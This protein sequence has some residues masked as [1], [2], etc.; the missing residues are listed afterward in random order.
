M[1]LS[2]WPAPEDSG[3]VGP[4]G[5]TGPKG[6]TG[7]TGA[8]GATGSTGPKGDTGPVGAT[9]ATGPAG[10]QGPKG[11][12]GTVENAVP[13]KGTVTGANIYLKG[14]G[15]SAPL[16]VYGNNVDDKRIAVLKSGSIYSNADANTLYSVGVG[17]T[18]TD[19]AGGSYV[20]AM[21][22]A[23]T[24][25][26][27][28][29]S[30]GV[31]A[32]SQGGVFKIKQAD[33]STVVPADAL[34]KDGGT[35]TGPVDLRPTSG[36]GFT[37]YGSTA[38]STYFRVTA[39]GHPYS[40]SERAT[41]YNIGV[42]DTST[43]FGGGVRVLGMQNASTVPTTNPPNGVVAYAQGGVMKVRQSDG[44]VITVGS[45]PDPPS[46]WEPE[47][48]GLK[49]WAGD[50]A[51]C[52]S[53]FRDGTTGKGR[54]SAIVVHQ[55]TTV[56]KIVWHFLGYAG[57]MKTGSWAGIYNTSGTLVRGTG[58]LGTS[59]YEP[60]EQHGVGG[61][62]S[63]SNLTSSVTLAP[64]VYYVAW[65]FNYTASPANGPLLMA[66]ESTDVSAT[67]YGLNA[68]RRFGAFST[69][70]GSAPSSVSG[71]ETDPI[72]FWVALA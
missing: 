32:Y 13:I 47:D 21:K 63:T 41:F 2:V 66:F 50:P 37:A 68:V 61:G 18:G 69:S 67:L 29:P 35:V 36:N 6:D 20:L 9:G 71:W 49:A 17:D 52:R 42:G 25:P 38:P 10:P 3:V 5:A 62:C 65:R 58:D 39:D 28:S 72:R 64:G 55:T 57:G 59:A 14:D 40:N 45:Q 53:G 33:G 30:N 22:N 60:A 46:G 16:N 44:Q 12:P 24:L 70:A 48:L 23:A 7:A 56:S 8:K 34:P 51:T 27:A 1:G 54:M 4:T 15:T 26:S 43:P 19:F 11:D 31:V